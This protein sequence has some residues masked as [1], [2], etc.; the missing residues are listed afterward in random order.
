MENYNSA[1][2]TWFVRWYRVTLAVLAPYFDQLSQDH[3]RVR[4]IGNPDRVILGTMETAV[5]EPV[6]IDETTIPEQFPL[7]QLKVQEW[8][9]YI[10]PR[11]LGQLAEITHKRF[12]SEANS[13]QSD[14]EVRWDEEVPQE[15]IQ[16]AVSLTENIQE[17]HMIFIDDN[18]AE[19]LTSL[20]LLII[21]L[22]GG[23]AY[24]RHQIIHF[25]SSYQRSTSESNGV[26][27]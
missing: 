12:E 21:G 3:D 10:T 9:H 20:F 7:R 25:E 26:R 18:L 14:D 4:K 15:A 19:V 22:F 16:D 2:G 11:T 6:Q 5:N 27:H 8:V 13:P 24:F 17:G 23:I 1:E